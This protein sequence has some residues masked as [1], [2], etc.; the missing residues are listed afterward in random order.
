MDNT[1]KVKEQLPFRRSRWPLRRGYATRQAGLPMVFG[2]VECFWPYAEASVAS[3]LEA[4][5]ADALMLNP[6]V[7]RS[8]A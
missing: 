8:I 5:A 3:L 7:T 6:V 2:A 1:D 4:V